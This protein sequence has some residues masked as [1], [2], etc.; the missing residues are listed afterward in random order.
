MLILFDVEVHYLVS[1]L[2]QFNEKGCG[3]CANCLSLLA[4]AAWFRIHVRKLAQ[5][6]CLYL[7]AGQS[8]WG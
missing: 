7:I 3:R 6:D 5:V 2:D 1:Q 8:E 4:V